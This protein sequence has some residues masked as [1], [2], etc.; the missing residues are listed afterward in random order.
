MDFMQ[1][2]DNIKQH[3]ETFAAEAKA[4]LEQELPVIAEVA[5]KTASNPAFDALASAV[6]LG[7]APELLQALAGYITA[8]ESALAASKAAGAA[9]AQ[10]AA[11]AAQAQ[12]TADPQ[13]AAAVPPQ[14]TA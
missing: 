4:K 12:A 3:L 11:A 7:Q 13:A 6:H 1:A 10:Q 14:P 8:A 9:E 2:V 5:T